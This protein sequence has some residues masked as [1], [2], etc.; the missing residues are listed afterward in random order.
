MALSRTTSSPVARPKFSD[1]EASAALANALRYPLGLESWRH[2]EDW[3]NVLMHRFPLWSFQAWAYAEVQR[4]TLPTNYPL[5]DMIDSISRDEGLEPGAPATLDALASAVDRRR[6][7]LLDQGMLGPPGKTLSSSRRP[8]DPYQRSPLKG[9]PSRFNCMYPL[10]RPE[11]FDP[12]DRKFAGWPY[13]DIG[14]ELVRLIRAQNAPDSTS[15]QEAKED[16]TRFL[17][18]LGATRGRGNPGKGPTADTLR[19]I[20]D[21]GTQL[22]S[23]CWGALP[24]PLSAKTVLR[25]GDLGVTQL[26]AQKS[27]VARLALPVFSSRETRVLLGQITRAKAHP[28]SKGRTPWSLAISILAHRLRMAPKTVARKVSGGEASEHVNWEEIRIQ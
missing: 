15:R 9:G 2:V 13:A 12:E 28:A 22:L 10:P 5:Q 27:W 14:R 6:Y 3:L 26:G 7:V 24:W 20:V 4:S 25:L 21:Q 18:S 23:L 8:T 17:G 11:D 19:L 16:L 1:A